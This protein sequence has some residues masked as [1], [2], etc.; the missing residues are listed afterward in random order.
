MRY[1][2]YG[3]GGIGSTVGGRLFASGCEVVLIARGA[4]RDAIARDGLRLATP[5]GETTIPVPAVGTIAEAAPRP[6]DVVVLAMKSQD[7]EAALEALADEADR[8]TPVLCLQNGV[9]NERL[10][11]RR[12]DHV[13]GVCVVLPATY[14][15]PGRVE[16][17]AAPV[18]GILDLGRYPA[19]VDGCCQLVAR[20]LEE[21][22]F[23]SRP[24][25]DVLRWKYG[26]LLVNLGNG[27]E[28]ACGRDALNSEIGRRLREEGCAC[29]ER[30]GI[31]IV[32]NEEDRERREVLRRGAIDGKSRQG[33]STWQSLV[34]GTGTSEADY[35]N[36]EIAMLGRL[37]GIPTPA[38]AIIQEVSR[39]MARDRQSPHTVSLDSLMAELAAADDALTAG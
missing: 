4:H 17:H 7:T 5:D 33:S 10:A 15:E 2:I 3:A 13:Y 30:A 14:L 8:R 27:L 20:D 36:G 28:A 31:E 22:G 6:G 37:Y 39:R 35:L 26:K 21:A 24:V 11:L 19:G 18:W 1:L 34:R 23:S 25:A 16:V 29:L 38:N 12:F 9:E 32:S